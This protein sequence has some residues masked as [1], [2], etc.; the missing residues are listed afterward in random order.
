MNINPDGSYSSG[1]F[2]PNNGS[3]SGPGKTPGGP[4]K[5]PKSPGSLTLEDKRK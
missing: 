2:N 4:N 1:P 3:G 5:A